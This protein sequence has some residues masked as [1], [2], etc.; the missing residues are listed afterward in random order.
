MY[1]VEIDKEKNLRNVSEN[2]I[3]R[4]RGGVEKFHIVLY[5]TTYIHDNSCRPTFALTLWASVKVKANN[6]NAGPML[7]SDA[8]RWALIHTEQMQGHVLFL[9]FFLLSNN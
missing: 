6:C 2:I 3:M 1:N 7:H 8:G 5:I 9:L 4:A